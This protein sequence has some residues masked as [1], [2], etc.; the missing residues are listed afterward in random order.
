VMTYTVSLHKGLIMAMPNCPKRLWMRL[1]R[2]A[3]S[4]YPTNG[5]RKM[6]EMVV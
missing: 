5:E 6:R 2:K 1:F 4:V 3:E